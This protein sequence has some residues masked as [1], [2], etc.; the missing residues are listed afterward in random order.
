MLKPVDVRLRFDEDAAP[1][2]ENFLFHP[3][4]TCARNNDG[5]VTV[6]FRA[7]GIEEMCWH[8][9]TW[10]DTVTVEGPPRL[11]RRL[12]EMCEA[13]AAHHQTQD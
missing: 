6:R 5:S 4:Q 11:R 13:I 7:C 10:G 3:S 8:L 12:V 9:V 1:D 2:A